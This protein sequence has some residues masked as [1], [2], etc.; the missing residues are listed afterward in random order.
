MAG[1]SNGGSTG[2]ATP[3][4]RDHRSTA[5]FS[6]GNF[7]RCQAITQQRGFVC[8]NLAFIADQVIKRRHTM[9]L[10]RDLPGIVGELIEPL[11]LSSRA[12]AAHVCPV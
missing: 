7:G 2:V 5:Q 6:A 1:R 11:T 3:F 10:K 8:D 12:A 9:N 4:E